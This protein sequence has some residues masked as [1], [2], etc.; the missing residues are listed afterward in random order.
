MA[1]FYFNKFPLVNYANSICRD[2][3]KRAVI[4]VSVKNTRTAFD[5]YTIRQESRADLIAENYYDD[6]Y[7]EWLLYMTNGIIDPYY[8][9]HLGV[10]DFNNHILKKYGSL[11]TAEDKIIYYQNNWVDDDTELTVSFF[12]NNLPVPLKKYYTPE[13][14]NGEK[15]L[16]YKRKQDDTK[17]NTNQIINITY[18]SPANKS[19]VFEV[20]ELLDIF[21]SSK[22]NINANT[23]GVNTAYDTIKVASANTLFNIGSEVLYV[24]PTGNTAI[25]GLSNNTNYYVTFANATD[26]A[27]SKTIGGSN[28]NITEI[29]TGTTE[30]HTLLTF[31]ASKSNLVGQGEIIYNDN[32]AIKIKNISG[33]TSIVDSVLLG[34]NSATEAILTSSAI[35]IKN[36]SDDEAVFWSPISFYTYELEINENNK[37][38]KLLDERY[39]MQ[40]SEDLRISLKT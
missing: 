20:G 22:I 6:P 8:G 21:S 9:W 11:E 25:T 40:I 12:E 1:E 7:Y 2:I 17:V 37:N 26:I 14:N 36:I 38:I 5:S 27:I 16:S 19:N 28:I 10:D 39:A 33:N 30:I 4:D 15:I 18:T 35:D 29:R 32:S 34:R 31:A 23:N 13:Y 24:V 3:T